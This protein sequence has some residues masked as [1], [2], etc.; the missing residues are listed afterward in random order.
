MVTTSAMGYTVVLHIDLYKIFPALVILPLALIAVVVHFVLQSMSARSKAELNKTLEEDRVVRGVAYGSGKAQKLA[1]ITPYHGESDSARSRERTDEALN[2]KG[3]LNTPVVP[4]NKHISRRASAVQGVKVLGKLRRTSSARRASVRN[5]ES[6]SSD[7]SCSDES[8]DSSGD[9]VEEIS[10]EEQAMAAALQR[11]RTAHA[12]ATMLAN[13]KADDDEEIDAF[14][15]EL[16]LDSSYGESVA[17]TISSGAHA[18]S[19][20]VAQRGAGL[21]LGVASQST[22]SRDKD[23]EYS[24]APK[25]VGE[26]SRFVGEDE[27]DVNLSDESSL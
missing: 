9:D 18:A 10:K 21:T 22:L 6:K 2:A 1:A 14:I 25:S 12:R 7:G 24:A 20:A 5:G 19:P 23:Y 11:E 8:D 15:A 27:E 26:D 13:L 3:A 16:E 17:S 4:I